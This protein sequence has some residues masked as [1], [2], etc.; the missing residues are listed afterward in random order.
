[1]IP[2]YI[3]NDASQKV[4]T[5]KKEGL[6]GVIDCLKFLNDNSII[7]KIDKTNY[8][9]EKE[10]EE[11][12]KLEQ[13]RLETEKKQLE[14]LERKIEKTKVNSIFFPDN[15]LDNDDYFSYLCNE[16][17]DIIDESEVEIISSIIDQ[18][19]ERKYNIRDIKE[20]LEMLKEIN[21]NALEYIEF[22]KMYKTVI[23]PDSITSMKD[24]RLYS[25]ELFKELLQ[26]GEYEFSWNGFRESLHFFPEDSSNELDE[27][28]EGHL[29]PQSYTL[30]KEYKLS[31]TYTINEIRAVMQEINLIAFLIIYNNKIK[32]RGG[33]YFVK[34]NMHKRDNN[35]DLR[36]YTYS[37]QLYCSDCGWRQNLLKYILKSEWEMNKNLIG[38]YELMDTLICFFNI[39]SV[40]IRENPN[41]N[42]ILLREL[43]IACKSDTYKSF[44]DDE[45]NYKKNRC[46]V[47]KHNK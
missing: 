34:C 8:I 35:F 47:K 1:M 5:S 46:A 13:E 11:I 42:E 14:E 7:N 24:K 20:E 25:D 45:A 37:K 39:S 32:F 29:Y 17:F 18:N 3:I 30:G 9:G 31:N 21:D 6:S 36:A 38:I 28:M 2:D 19:G 15:N 16:S 40:Q 44:L 43:I 23:Y 26:D 22:L 41:V 12:K 27:I 4:I 33:D 10:K